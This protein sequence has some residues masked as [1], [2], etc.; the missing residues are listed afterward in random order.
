MTNVT[1]IDWTIKTGDK[2]WSGTDS[3]VKIE[4]Y[5]DTQMLKRLNL[6]PGHTPRLNRSE[7]ATYYWV[8]QSPDGIGVAVSGTAVPYYEAFP[9]G[10]SGHLRVKFVAKGDDAWEKAWLESVVYSGELK[11][12]PGTIDS[13]KWVENWETFIFDRDVVLSTD[14]SEGFASLTLHY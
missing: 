8:F 11:H 14:R 2:W 1:R 6:E 9:H 4:I 7:L 10:V 3:P 13:V 12:V 5:R